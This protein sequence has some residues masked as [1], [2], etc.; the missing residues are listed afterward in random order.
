MCVEGNVCM[1]GVC[2]CVCMYVCMSVYMYVCM[3]V[4]VSMYMF[5]YVCMYVCMC[6]GDSC[7]STG[8]LGG[9][10]RYSTWHAEAGRNNC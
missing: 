8:S 2:V 6:N 4:C 3:C 7:G 10:H 1:Y 9:V 5:M